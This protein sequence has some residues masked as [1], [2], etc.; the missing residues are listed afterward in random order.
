MSSSRRTAHAVFLTFL[1]PFRTFQL[2]A[3]LV[4]WGGTV[5]V[6]PGYYSAAGTYNRAMTVK[7]PLGAV[8]L[9]G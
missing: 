7:A 4:P 3:A 9:G 5:W 6:Q 2:G 1:Y 8:T